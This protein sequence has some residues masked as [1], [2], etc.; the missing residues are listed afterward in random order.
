MTREVKLTKAIINLLDRGVDAIIENDTI[1]VLLND[2][3]LELSEFE[4][5]FQAKECADKY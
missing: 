2:N 1:Y 4:I 5:D 3:Q